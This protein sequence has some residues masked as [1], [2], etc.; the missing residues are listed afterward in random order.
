MKTIRLLF[1]TALL[2]FISAG[3]AEV[4]GVVRTA[5]NSAGLKSALSAA[6]AGDTIKLLGNVIY[7]PGGIGSE[8]IAFNVTK[9]VTIIGGWQPGFATRVPANKSILSGN[10][11]GANPVYNRAVPSLTGLD[12]N[13]HQIIV[14]NAPSKSQSK[15]DGVIIT[16]GGGATTINNAT[17]LT[18][19]QGNLD[20]VN[21][22]FTH[23]KRALHVYG[24]ETHLK[25]DSCTFTENYSGTFGTAV[26]LLKS[27]EA[28]ITNSVFDNNGAA[29]SPIYLNNGAYLTVS[30]STF[31][32]NL[33]TT[34]GG[35]MIGVNGS[36]SE[37]KIM[38]STF[39]GNMRAFAGNAGDISAVL[40][41]KGKA[42][43]YHCTFIGNAV[44]GET[45]HAKGSGAKITYGGNVF[46]G[47]TTNNSKAKAYI[48]TS[49]GA[50]YTNSGYN[51]FNTGAGAGI[52]GANDVT[53]IPSSGVNKYFA[54]GTPSDSLYTALL[55]QPATGFT[56]V[57]MPAGSDSANLIIVPKA[58]TEAWVSSV[59]GAPP[60][61]LTDQRNVT[62]EATDNKYFAGAVNPKSSGVTLDLTVFLQGV[63]QANGTMTNYIQTAT[64]YSNLFPYPMLPTTDPYSGNVT[65]ADINNTSIAGAVVDWIQVEI[66]QI[67]N[68]STKI[69]LEEKALLLRPNGKIV[70]ID[71][72]NPSF[73]PR[74]GPVRIVI[75]HRNHLGVMS[76][77]ITSFTGT[78]TYNFSSAVS[79]SEAGTG[80]PMVKNNA[81]NVWCL[82]AGDVISDGAIDATD[83]SVFTI[84]YTRMEEEE[85]LNTDLNMDGAV[86]ALDYSL[87]NVNFNE[88]IESILF[89]FF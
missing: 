5:S 67:V 60:A 85:Y 56:P 42:E 80:A 57:I 65:F 48:K 19:L 20:I 2:T 37:A 34:Q 7:Q 64:G 8:D 49:E 18:L 59:W 54:G 4:F 66:W 79:Q 88:M 74:T 89:D 33:I 87:M 45:L 24:V 3:Q 6:N 12:D 23:N 27:V 39:A 16:G 40:A 10:Y 1:Y 55:T 41:Y 13:A 47:N 72:S 22:T 81:A 9:A 29:H 36:T 38:F 70:D 35:A 84:S 26:T 11:N 75:K 15:L 68:P 86:D 21:T 44:Q 82:W 46:L 17:G 51:V 50:T 14:W 32:N 58:T 28:I 69:I 43:A 25:I 73:Q 78:V 76:N 30:H 31:K 52:A 61:T 83:R 63:T 77:A 71:G 62:M 53:N